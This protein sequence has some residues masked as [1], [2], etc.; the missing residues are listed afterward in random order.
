[1]KKLLLS[2][3]VILLATGAFAQSTTGTTSR[4]GIKAGVNLAKIHS[5]GDNEAL[6]NDKIGRAHV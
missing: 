1:M 6:Y 2:A 5:S 3:S 4:F